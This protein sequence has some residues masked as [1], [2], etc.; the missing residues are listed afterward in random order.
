LPTIQ[1][2]KETAILVFSRHAEEEARHKKYGRHLSLKNG[3]RLASHL[4]QHTLKEVKQTGLPVIQFFTDKQQGTSFGERLTNA[5]EQGFGLG[6]KQLIVCGTDA[7][8]INAQQLTGVAEKL[9]THELV[10]GPS[11]DGGVYLIGIHKNSF[12]KDSFLQIPWL[13]EGVFSSLQ[14]YALSHSLRLGIEAVEEDI[15]T[16]DAA[17]QWQASNKQHWFGVLLH[18][19]LH[20]LYTINYFHFQTY[21]HKSNRS[22]ASPLRGPPQFCY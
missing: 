19:L 11:A 8:H 21:L 1:T 7:P 15:D 13:S 16:I 2:N 14:S 4:I 10:L 18:C 9:Y 12:D 5:I 3:E 6:F 17:F 22:S 20:S